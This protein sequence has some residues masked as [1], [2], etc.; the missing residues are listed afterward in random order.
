[1]IDPVATTT[2]SADTLPTRLEVQQLGEVTV[3][4][5]LE[6]SIQERETIRS[7]RASFYARDRQVPGQFLLNFS[8][9]EFL[10]GDAISELI[11]LHKHLEREGHQL[12]L[13]NLH[14]SI[15]EVFR[16]TQLLDNLFHVNHEAT[17]ALPRR[18][19]QLPNREAP[20]SSGAAIPDDLRRMHVALADPNDEQVRRILKALPPTL[21][22]VV[23]TDLDKLTVACRNRMPAA[24]LL[25][26]PWGP[27]DAAKKE[28]AVLNF[29]RGFGKLTTILVYAATDRLSIE[30]YCQLL[31]AGAKQI[32]NSEAASFPDELL[33]ALVRLVHAFQAAQKEQQELLSVFASHGVVGES[34]PMVEVFRRALKAAQFH[35]LPVLIEGETGTGKQRLAEAIHCLD[36]K[37]SAKPFI[38]L[39]C[40]A[41]SK[42]LAE[43]ELFGHT[44][45]A[46]SGAQSERPGIFQMADGGTLLL[47]EIMELDLELQPKLLRVL[48]EHR[49]LPV[50]ADYERSVDVRIIASTNRSL[51]D[52]IEQGQFREDL[53]QR[54]NVFRIYIPPLRERPACIEEQARHFLRIHQIGRERRV[55]DFGLR[56]LEALRLLPWEGNSR[57]LENLIRETLAHKE[58][59]TL[60]QMEDL[61]HWVLD[62]LARLRPHAPEVDSHETLV[63]KVYDKRL[64]LAQAMT[65][66]ERRLLQVVLERNGGNRTLTAA[67]LGMTPRSVLNKIKKFG[68]E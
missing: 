29:L 36:P 6:R 56:V 55:T 61:P 42:T 37:R 46:F 64:S 49:L 24:I 32:V 33:Q 58:Q 57:Q 27:G 13:S 63:E 68:L 47:D 18:G 2:T 11:A 25:P 26:M 59:G 66:F 9:V 3:V 21:R 23:Y 62:T 50:G 41:V 22:S 43:S 67:E 35:D 45:G 30:E 54:L 60:L 17:D 38:T 7:A 4:N 44:K 1:M 39:N 19:A 5:F 65:E 53:Y 12:L 34:A 31:A 15:E 8:S 40:S 48:Q 16:E 28:S 52:M 20:G 14:P 51:R 10:G